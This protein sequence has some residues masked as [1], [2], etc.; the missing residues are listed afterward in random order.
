M[1]IP[2]PR[3]GED[4]SDFMSRCM[5]DETMLA[6][7]PEQDQRA[8]VC[9]TQWRD[10]D[11]AADGTVT[12][13]KAAPPPNGDPLEYVMSDATVDRMGD[14][15]EPAGWR[16]DNFRKNPIAL[17]GHKGDFPIGR[18][19]D[20]G[21]KNGQL[22]GR[23]ELLEPV[24]YRLR[25]IHAAVAAGVLRAVSVGFHPRRAEPRKGADGIRYTEQDLVECS[26]VSV[27]ANPN[28]LAIVKA[29]NLSAQTRQL[30]FGVP[31]GD[32]QV[33]QRGLHGVTARQVPRKQTPMNISER[34][35][36]A[37][38]NLVSLRE[39]LGVTEADDLD[40]MAD[41]TAKIDEVQGQ[42]QVWEKAEKALGDG[43]QPIAVPASR[44]TILP[45]GGGMPARP[46]ATPKKHFKGDDLV[47]R[48]L[49]AKVISHFSKTSITDVL[50]DHY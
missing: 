23:L 17:F 35:E 27:P 1:P 15:L 28:A 3:A 44:T 22:T 18:W 40:K 11:K 12:K 24:S 10:R 5:G 13:T 6:D 16:L 41:L 46:W 37:Q 2:T 45:P 33:T 20:V 42:L 25:E 4:E 19:R 36:Q 30:I 9:G 32:D 39:Q 21:V 14:V 26:L 43:S 31:A 29:L 50:R 49:T 34:I 7:Y 47:F 8:A 48:S 38:S